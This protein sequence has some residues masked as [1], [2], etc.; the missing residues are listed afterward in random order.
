MR[1]EYL[2][3]IFEI[4]KFSFEDII[5]ATTESGVPVEENVATGGGR[6]PVDPGEETWPE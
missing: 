6:D 2:E 1:K 5:A 4:E 3:P